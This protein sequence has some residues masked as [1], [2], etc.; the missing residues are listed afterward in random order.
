MK[1]KR[2]PTDLTDAQ[3]EKLRPL[4]EKAR[5]PRGRPRKYAL[6]EIV[7]ALL[8]VLRGGISWRAMP[9]DFPPWESVYDHFRR[10]RQGSTLEQIHEVLR[11]ETREKQGRK[12]TPTAAVLDTQ[13]VKT[14]GK[15][16]TPT[17][18]TRARRSRAASAT[19][20]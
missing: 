4:L 3:W 13:S 11:E 2:Y 12:K 20:S 10:W 7:N 1:R 8:Y 19:S 14:A 18:T 6:R 17:A 9:H 16:G 15:R 5:D